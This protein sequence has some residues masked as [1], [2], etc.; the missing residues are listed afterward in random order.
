MQT[1]YQDKHLTVSRRLD[2]R[3][4][5]RCRHCGKRGHKRTQT[6]ATDRGAWHLISQHRITAAALA[7]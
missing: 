2:G 1:V 5:W 3:H 7:A 4:E 6:G